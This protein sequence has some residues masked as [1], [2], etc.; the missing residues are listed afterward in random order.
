M[1]RSNRGA[2]LLALRLVGGGGEFLRDLLELALGGEQLVE[3]ALGFVEERAAGG[4]LGDLRQQA[5]ARAGVQRD[6][7]GVGF[8]QPGE[9]AQQRRLAGPVGAD[10]PDPLAGVDL[11]L[12][13]LE[14][15]RRAVPAGHV[16]AGQEE[17]AGT[18]KKNLSPRP[19]PLRR[20]GEQEAVRLAP[21]LAKPLHHAKPLAASRLAPPPFLG[22]GAGGRGSSS[23]HQ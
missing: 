7:A 12:D 16:R 10:E 9:D 1:S 18:V 22:E 2:E 20:E 5:E 8:V 14:Q 13:A 4:E 6:L 3:R 23:P 19:P 21:H 15:R 11:E 17:H